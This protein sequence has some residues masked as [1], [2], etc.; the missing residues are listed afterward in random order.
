MTKTPPE[1]HTEIMAFFEDH[2]LTDV[3]FQSQRLSFNVIDSCRMQIDGF[4]HLTT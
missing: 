2:L 1:T 3:S 4:S